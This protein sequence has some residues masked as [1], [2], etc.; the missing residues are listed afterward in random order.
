MVIHM[1]RI[2]RKEK[3]GGLRWG[4]SPSGKLIIERIKPLSAKE[5][6]WFDDLRRL[7]ENG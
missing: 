1:P 3:K 7:M 6:K 5:K 2:K 4:R